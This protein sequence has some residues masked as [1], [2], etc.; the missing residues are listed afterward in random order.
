[1]IKGLI[2]LKKHIPKNNCMICVDETKSLSNQKRLFLI[3]KKILTISNFL[4]VQR[5]L[6]KKNIKFLEK[7]KTYLSKNYINSIV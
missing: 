5:I 7:L 1:M 6:Q 3:F 2:A 4:E